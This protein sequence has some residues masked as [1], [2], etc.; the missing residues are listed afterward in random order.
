VKGKI[1]KKF[2]KWMGFVVAGLA[3]L[4][5][6]ALAWVYF[7]SERE[8]GRRFVAADFAPVTVPGTEA[9]IAEGKRVAALAG[10]MHCHGENLAGAVVDDIPNL[11]RLVAPNASVLLPKYSDAQ[12]V[13][14]LR[15]GV[16]PDGTSVLFMPSEMFRHLGDQ[17]LGRL[18]AW[19]R[20][21]PVT[22]QGIREKTELRILARLL[23]AKGDLKASAHA[24]QTLPAAASNFDAQDPVSHGRNLTMSFCSECHGQGLE[25]FAPIN[26]P[27]LDV[28][29]AYT[30]DQFANLLRAGVPLDGRNL[31]LMGPTAKVR[32]SRLRDDEVAAIHAFLQSR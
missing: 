5:L 1:V 16:K 7:A 4:V 8:I 21:V 29:K 6:L 31:P 2:F 24:I 23:L 3:G 13:T 30:L 20:T 11:L 9:E 26:A 25:G 14:M 19:L 10:C 15:A 28:A 17:D 18:I 22:E 12:L 32:F 27:P